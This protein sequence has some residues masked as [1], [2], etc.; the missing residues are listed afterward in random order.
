MYREENP[1]IYLV[2][3]LSKTLHATE[4]GRLLPVAWTRTKEEELNSRL[5]WRLLVSIDNKSCQAQTLTVLNYL[6]MLF[7]VTSPDKLDVTNMFT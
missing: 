4:K 6:A 2:Q 1:P 3:M 5:H 7:C